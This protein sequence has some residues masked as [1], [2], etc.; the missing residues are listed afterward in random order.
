MMEKEKGKASLH[1]SRR[2]L[3]FAESKRQGSL[4]ILMHYISSYEALK[5]LVTPAKQV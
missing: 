2:E 5:S 3:H 4:N 1:P